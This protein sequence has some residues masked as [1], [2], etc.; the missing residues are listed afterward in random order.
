MKL[1]AL[2]LGTLAQGFL[3]LFS[4][5]MGFKAALRLASYAAWITVLT[6]YAASVIVCVGSL[7]SMVASA[8]GG[9]GASEWL[10]RFWMGVGMFIPSNAG[11]VIACVGSVW[12]ASSIYAMQRDGLVNFGPQ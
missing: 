3:A 10:W 12:I 2:F 11:A 1:F 5:F 9:S 8:S 7:A 4:R 6:T